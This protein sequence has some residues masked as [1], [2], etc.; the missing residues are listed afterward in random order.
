MVLGLVCGFGARAYAAIIATAKSLAERGHP[1]VRIGAASAMLVALLF[2]SDAIFGDGLSSGSGYRTLEWVTEPGHGIGLVIALLVVRVMATSATLA[3]GGVGGLFVPLVIAG[4]LIGD[5]AATAIGDTTNLFPLIGIAALLGAGYRTPLAGVVFVAEATGRPGFIVPGLIASVAAQLVM[6]DASVSRY[7]HAGRH[8]RLEH[9]LRLPVASAIRADVLTVPAD[10]TV[11]EFYEQHLM[12]VR[13]PSVAVL[14]GRDYLGMISAD[15]LREHEPQT[16]DDLTVGEVAHTDWPT[17]RPDWALEDA[18]HSMDRT[19][20][21]TLPVLDDDGAFIGVITAT[22]II[23][24]DTI[25]GT[26]RKPM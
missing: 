10:A 4:A 9:R 6:G 8:G 12:L 21:D 24:L 5:A 3:G 18:M 16:W 1:A 17:A 15:D 20:V 23:R 11:R 25:I 19:D 14:D 26:D 22:D 2:T 7:Q 13:E